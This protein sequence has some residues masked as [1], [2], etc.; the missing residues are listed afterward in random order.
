MNERMREMKDWFDN[1]VHENDQDD[2]S[3]HV[4]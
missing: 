2:A 3:E 4:K 1:L